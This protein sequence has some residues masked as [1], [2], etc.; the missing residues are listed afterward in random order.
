MKKVSQLVTGTLVQGFIICKRQTWLMAHQIVPDQ[1]HS[2]LEIGRLIDEKSYDRS[3][4]KV[5]LDNVVL[6]LVRSEEGDLVVGE[7]KK[8]SKGAESA[9]MQLAF[10]L[11]KLKEYGIDARGRLLFPEERR[12]IDVELDDKM[13]DE[14]ENIVREIEDIIKEPFPP[15]FKKIAFCKHCAY[16][17]FCMS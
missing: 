13:I 12:R 4:K 5:H 1:E 2:Y 10:Y 8:S 15:P 17:E 11:Y 6:D 14:I 16:K 9:K 7:I 3:R